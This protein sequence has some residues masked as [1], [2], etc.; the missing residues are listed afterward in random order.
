MSLSWTNTCIR[1]PS[2]F[3]PRIFR[4]LASACT[5]YENLLTLSQRPHPGALDC[6]NV[7]EH[8]GAPPS[9]WMKPKPFCALNHLK[10][11]SPRCGMRRVNSLTGETTGRA[12][13]VAG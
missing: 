10:S 8:V 13:I 6:R 7:Y 3:P 5:S 9:G 2:D 1:R 11:S 4:R 12:D